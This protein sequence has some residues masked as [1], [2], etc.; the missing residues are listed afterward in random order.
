MGK[1]KKE[2]KASTI[3]AS[4]K[5]DK[6][7]TLPERKTRSSSSKTSEE[8]PKKDRETKARS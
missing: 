3:L 4:I 5:K 6:A 2:V 1:K 8:A 7:G